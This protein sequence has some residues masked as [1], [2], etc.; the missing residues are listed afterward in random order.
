MPQVKAWYSRYAGD[1]LVIL[2]IHTPEFAYEA[3]PEN[4]AD[5]VDEQG[6]GYPVA[7]DPEGQIWR[8]WGNH[9]WPAFYLY[10]EA[11]RLR[12]RHFGEG[13]YATIEDAIRVLLAV[14]PSSRRAIVAA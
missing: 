4:V 3:V 2:S 8:T 14:N 9:Y 11:G 1:G 7:L 12:L 5:Y 13:S 10:D 6:I